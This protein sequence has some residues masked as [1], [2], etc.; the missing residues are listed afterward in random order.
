VI[1]TDEADV[2]IERV[3]R[4]D[5]PVRRKEAAGQVER[6]AD[7]QC[8]DPGDLR[9]AIDLHARIAP[10]ELLRGSLLPCIQEVRRRSIHCQSKLLD[11]IGVDQ[12]CGTER[13]GG[14]HARGPTG[15]LKQVRIEAVGISSMSE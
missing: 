4:A 15:L 6:A 9:S 1:A 7:V 8:I 2:V 13:I 5:V 11:D 14:L 12:I 10:I 3:R